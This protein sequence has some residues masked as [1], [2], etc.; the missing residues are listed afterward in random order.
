[1]GRG[2]LRCQGGGFCFLLK[3]PGG[4]GGGG[5]GSGGFL[6]VIGGGGLNV[7]LFGAEISTK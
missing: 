7:F 4:G 1:M 3:I 6:R 2:S 5:E